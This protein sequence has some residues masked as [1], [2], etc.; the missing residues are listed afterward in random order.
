MA[1]GTD[2][3]WGYFAQTQANN[4]GLLTLQSA[5]GAF[6]TVK[7]NGRVGIYNSN[8]SAALEIGTSG[9][10]YQLK[11]NG[12][13]VWG[14]DERIKENIKNVSQSVGKLKQ[15]RGVTYRFKS[16]ISPQYVQKNRSVDSM[17]KPQFIPQVDTSI[18]NRNHYGLLAQDV[19]RLFP[20]LVY[21]DSAGML[22][23]DYIGLIPLIIEALKEDSQTKDSLINVL[24][25]QI[26][27]LQKVTALQ[28]KTIISLQQQ[29]NDLKKNCCPS[30]TKSARVD[31][32]A[33]GMSS[34]DDTGANGSVLYQNSPNP[35]N[36]NTTIA[37]F[38]S[39]TSV[40]A[41]LYIFNMSGVPIRTIPIQDKGYGSITIKGSELNAGM[42]LYTLIVDGKEVDTKRMILTE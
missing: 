21:K 11:V 8:P 32:T 7:A 15:L 33:T 37:Y 25:G 1:A 28:E 36:Q 19:Q 24:A 14:S 17:E 3:I 10:S 40:S 35:F 4:P 12:A 22:G 9:T 13:V 18:M 34:S 5:N 23:I 31:E 29:I 6:F 42:Y 38:V 30:K 27:T 16:S 39:E 2:L 41:T 20:D 26:A